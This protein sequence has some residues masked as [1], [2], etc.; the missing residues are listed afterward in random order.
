MLVRAVKK[1]ILWDFLTREAWQYLVLGCGRE[2]RDSIGKCLPSSPEEDDCEQLFRKFAGKVPASQ[3]SH[4][5]EFFS[6][7]VF[8]P[9]FCVPE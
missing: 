9:V 1:L 8:I 4:K 3:S 6:H 5:I 7:E 2:V